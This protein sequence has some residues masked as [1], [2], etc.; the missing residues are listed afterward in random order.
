MPRRRAL[1]VGLALL[2]PLARH[3]RAASISALEAARIERLLQFVESQKQCKFVRSGSAY[4]ARE[5]AQFLR[6]KYAKMGEHVTT[7]A[8]F[9]DQIA[10]RSSTSGQAY[11]L[12]YPDG[13]TVP[14]AQ[15]LADELRRI[16]R[17]R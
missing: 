1:W 5:G 10:A 13:R 14:A 9:I 17:Q 3:A 6:A 12:R 8:Q 11:L 15:V 2:A 16:D 7:A 4:T